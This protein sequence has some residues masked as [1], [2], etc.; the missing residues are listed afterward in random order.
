[1][2]R[3]QYNSTI[4]VRETRIPRSPI[5]RSGETRTPRKRKPRKPGGLPVGARV[6]FA[7]E[8]LP[9]TVQ[10]RSS[11][12]LV[13]SKPFAARRTV[14]Y[15]IIDLKERVRGPENLV[16]GFGAETRAQCERMVRRLEDTDDPT[17]VSHRHRIDLVVRRVEHPLPTKVPA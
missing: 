9:Y 15:C 8:K 16:F 5:A 6:W 11:R 3:L 17:E 10:A 1:M 7:E 4:A 14:L 2:K 12:F 13:C